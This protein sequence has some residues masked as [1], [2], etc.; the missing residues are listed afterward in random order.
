VCAM[1]SPGPYEPVTFQANRAQRARRR[2]VG[3]LF[4][5]AGVGLIAFSGKAGTGRATA[6]LII[7]GLCFAALG[8]LALASR[9]AYTMID[10]EGIHTS[11]PWGRRS[12]RWADVTD[13][14][15]KIEAVDGPPMVY[16]IKIHRRGGRSFTLAAPTD[17]ETK[18]RHDNPE[19]SQ[20]LAVINSYWTNGT[21]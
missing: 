2:G 21:R 12:C 6:G 5:V 14:E 13:V 4:L 11:G 18:G 7:A 20:Q 19:F 17:A 16:N 10:A 8:V 15:L 1:A 9:R 3:F